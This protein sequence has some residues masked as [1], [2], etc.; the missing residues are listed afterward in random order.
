MQD[1]DPLYTISGGSP[2]I[3]L[4]CTYLEMNSNVQFRRTRFCFVVRLPDDGHPV[5]L[6]TKSQTS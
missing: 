1:R 3:I 4:C 5:R 6:V 2:L